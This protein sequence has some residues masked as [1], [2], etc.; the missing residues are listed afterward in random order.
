MQRVV[1]SK[2]T[3]DN[4]VSVSNDISEQSPTLN[5]HLNAE[6][7]SQ[8][9]SRPMAEQNRRLASCIGIE[10][11]T[12]LASSLNAEHQNSHE[13]SPE[14]HIDSHFSINLIPDIDRPSRQEGDSL[15]PIYTG[16]RLCE[17]IQHPTYLL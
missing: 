6:P 12:V 17:T 14:I 2:T 1:S 11:S 4:E 3:D 16:N 15:R 10:Q 7:S 9:A 5:S 13:P 8:Q